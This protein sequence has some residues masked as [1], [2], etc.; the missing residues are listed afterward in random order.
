VETTD[1]LI[2]E[3]R[4]RA[5]KENK[6]M[7]FVMFPRS[8]KEME[9]EIRVMKAAVR[10]ITKTPESAREFMRKHGFITKGNK[11]TKRYR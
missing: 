2:L 7:S 10:E 3:H 8:A 1:E 11:L 4:K 5:Y 6:P 9:K